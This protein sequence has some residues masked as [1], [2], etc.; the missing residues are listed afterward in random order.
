M[1][2]R[3]PSIMIRVDDPAGAV[4]PKVRRSNH[5]PQAMIGV[6]VTAIRR[7]ARQVGA[8]PGPNCIGT[9]AEGMMRPKVWRDTLLMIAS[10]AI[11]RPSTIKVSQSISRAPSDGD[12]RAQL[13]HAARRDLEEV[14]GIGSIAH[15]EDE[16]LVLP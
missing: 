1:N 9:L 16:D 15:Q 10:E 14:R 13:D 8:P 7:E 11:H 6:K 5:T 2:R 3:V 12:L 4:W